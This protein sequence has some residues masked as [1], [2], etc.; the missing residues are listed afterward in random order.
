MENK[1][2]SAEELA[3][4]TEAT[5]DVKEDEVRSQVISDYGFDETV[6]GERIDKLVAKEVESRKK[7]SQAI[8]QKRK[9]REEAE[10]LKTTTPPK[11]SKKEEKE[12]GGPKLSIKDMHALKDVHED[13]IDDVIEYAN[14]KKIPISEAKKSG[15]VQAILANK[16]E[17]RKTAAATNTG[18][19]KPPIKKLT[20]DALIGEVEK[21]NIPEAGSKEAEDYF[22]AKRGGRRG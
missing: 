19:G 3:L 2:L 12:D 9:Y 11:E 10:K 20:D 18:G 7:L 17:T 1:S 16:A 5:Q 13:D 8:G 14:F 21:G 4:E 22:W 15:A 6:D